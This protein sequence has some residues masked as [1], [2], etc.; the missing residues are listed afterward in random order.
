MFCLIFAVSLGSC[1][2]NQRG[3]EAGPSTSEESNNTDESP[4][5]SDEANG[6]ASAGEEDASSALVDADPTAPVD[7]NVFNVG[8]TVTL[9]MNSKGNACV[10]TKYNSSG[11]LTKSV[12]IAKDWKIVVGMFDEEQLFVKFEKKPSKIEGLVRFCNLTHIRTLSVRKGT[13][14]SA[15]VGKKASDGSL[16][17]TSIKMTEE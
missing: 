1:S 16:E 11:T 17:F 6:N 3:P 2:K 15:V 7:T 14:T 9:C 4:E 13:T 12:S 8:D 10:I 5:N